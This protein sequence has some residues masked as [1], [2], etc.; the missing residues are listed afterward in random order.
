MQI[1][2]PE[3]D[4][5]T[6]ITQIEYGEIVSAFVPKADRGSKMDL[7][8]HQEKLIEVV[9]EYPSIDRIVV[10]DA[11]PQYAEVSGDWKGRAVTFRYKK[12]IKIV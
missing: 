5:L 9:R 6:L 10:H 3:R 1:S 4:L 7:E 2:D 8:P 12:K 11:R